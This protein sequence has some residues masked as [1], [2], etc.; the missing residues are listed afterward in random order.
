MMFNDEINCIKKPS[1]L[2]EGSFIKNI[3]ITSLSRSNNYDDN[4]DRNNIYYLFFHF[5]N[6]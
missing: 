2:L 5:S 1:I 4:D 6:I 3:N